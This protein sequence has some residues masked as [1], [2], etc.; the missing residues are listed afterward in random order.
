MRVVLIVV[1]SFSALAH[2]QSHP[3]S[4][5]EL[6]KRA[7][8][9]DGQVVT[10]QGQ[11]APGWEYVHIYSEACPSIAISL[12]EKTRSAEFWSAVNDHYREPGPCTLPDGTGGWCTFSRYTVTATLKGRFSRKN[13]LPMHFDG[14]LTIQKVVSFEKKE[15]APPPPEGL[16]P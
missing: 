9:L 6:A 5:C 12:D 4:V 11:I 8:H 10:V 2:G 14:N 1:L 3:L 7:K 15:N 16:L 13:Q